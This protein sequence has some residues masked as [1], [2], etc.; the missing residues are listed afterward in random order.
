M[1][2]IFYQR[3]AR[4]DCSFDSKDGLEEELV[5]LNWP[6]SSFRGGL[7]IQKEMYLFSYEININKDFMF[8]YRPFVL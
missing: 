8:G 7:N 4:L 3:K 1:R 6:L 2:V 5:P